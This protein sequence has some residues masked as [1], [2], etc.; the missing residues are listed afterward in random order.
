MTMTRRAL[1]GWDYFER[2]AHTDFASRIDVYVYVYGSGGDL[3][4]AL[5]LEIEGLFIVT[6]D[7]SYFALTG[8]SIAPL[9]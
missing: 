9:F 6:I 2:C 4:Q 3:H 1:H 7:I 8:T 5:D